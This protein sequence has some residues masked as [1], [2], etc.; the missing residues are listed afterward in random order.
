LMNWA[1]STSLLTAGKS[2]WRRCAG[3]LYHPFLS[4]FGLLAATAYNW[5]NVET[6]SCL[7]VIAAAVGF[8][9]LWSG[10]P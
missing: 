5:A 3:K 8:S 6:D 2:G 4:R 10:H 1:R 7:P 9:R